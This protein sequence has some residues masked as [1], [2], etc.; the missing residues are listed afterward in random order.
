LVKFVISVICVKTDISEMQ[1]QV[2][3]WICSVC[4]R[5]MSGSWLICGEMAHPRSEG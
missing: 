2:Q 5:L 4:L 3:Q 1:I